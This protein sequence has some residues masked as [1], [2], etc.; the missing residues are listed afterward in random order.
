MSKVFISKKQRNLLLNS[1]VISK[2]EFTNIKLFLEENQK[3]SYEL[4]EGS[5]IG[6]SLQTILPSLLPVAQSEW[7][8]D[9][10]SP[11]IDLGNEYKSLGQACSLCGKKPLRWKC[12]IKNQY[13]GITLIVGS[14]CAKEFGE[15]MHLRFKHYMKEAER[16]ARIKRLNEEF[17]G[18]SK[19]I[20]NW[21]KKIDDFPI[22]IAEELDLKW[23]E[24][25]R[26]LAL[27]YQDFLNGKNKKGTYKNIS[28]LIQKSDKL[29]IEIEEFVKTN[30]SKLFITSRELATWLIA[31]QKKSVLE[32]IK[33][34]SGMITWKTA[35]RITEET[36]MSDLAQKFN[37]YL[38]S[39]GLRI[40]RLDKRGKIDYIFSMLDFNF[41]HI[42][43][44]YSYSEFVLNYGGLIFKEELDMPVSL[45]EVFMGGNLYGRNSYEAVLEQVSELITSY[46]LVFKSLSDNEIIFENNGEYLLVSY[47]EIAEKFKS[48]VLQQNINEQDIT[49]YLETSSKK[50]NKRVYNLHREAKQVA[51]EETR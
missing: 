12:P 44:T 8:E 16:A 7:I 1:S 31:N 24:I 15:V 37:H 38:K 21:N 18:I 45:Y 33:K 49:H 23:R 25:G 13:N 4:I 41:K 5:P 47:K 14:E 27:I 20:E 17:P 46:N 40:D 2:K 34:D 26:R 28:E 29:L 35:H 10:D 22:V 6:Q 32:L 42:K 30:Q 50:M 11:V 3:I 36:F 9:E 51:R 19:K 48:L 43:F 39:S